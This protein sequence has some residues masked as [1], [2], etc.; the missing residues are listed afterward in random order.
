MS[1]SNWKT[2]ILNPVSCVFLCIKM[3]FR[4][5]HQAVCVTCVE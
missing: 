3:M 2:K 4:A 5:C 1:K